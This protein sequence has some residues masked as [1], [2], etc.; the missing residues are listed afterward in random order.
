M[1]I[2]IHTTVS[3][4]SLPYYEYMEKNYQNL[5]SGNNVL[6]FFVYCLDNHAFETIKSKKD[7]EA[8]FLGIKRGTTA[9]CDAA[10]FAI[11]QIKILKNDINIIADSDTVVLQRNW[12]DILINE[13]SKVCVLGSTYEPFGG[14]SSGTGNVQTYKNAPNLTW[15]AISP[16]VDFSDID[17]TP[18]K[19]SHLEILD[20]EMA[21][22]YQIP[23]GFFLLRDTGWQIPQYLHDKK[24]SYGILTHEKPTKNAKIIKTNKDYHEEYQLNG[25]PFVAHQR[26][27]MSQ[28]FRSTELSSTFYS[29][30]DSYFSSI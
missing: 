20:E 17:L 30:L 25:L 8:F 28:A 3:D 16:N 5:K 24:I 11:K 27:S 12:D 29:A 7:C 4:N 18:N 26:G 15:F 9:H 23:K 19:A 10:K 22:I 6:R 1:Q 13:L 2:N 21:E 14:F